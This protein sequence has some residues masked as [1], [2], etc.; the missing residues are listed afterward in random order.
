MD[1][2]LSRIRGLLNTLPRYTRPTIHIAGTNGK[3]SV[4][5]L[6]DSILRQAQ[7]RTGRFNSP[8]LIE[9]RDSIS[10]D[11]NT[12]PVDKYRNFRSAVEKTNTFGA[13]SFE[14]LTVTALQAFEQEGVDIAI[15]EV[16]LGGRLD[17]TN[18]IP[19]D[20]ILISAITS[21]DLDHQ[22][23]LGDTI[24]HIA[25]EKAGI[26]RKGVPLVLGKQSDSSVC[27]AITQVV[28]DAGGTVVRAEDVVTIAAAKKQ[29]I[30]QQVFAL[31]QIVIAYHGHT[32]DA[33]M[34]LLGSHQLDNAAL[35]VAI[36]LQLR[37]M[38]SFGFIT[39]E[40]I[41][42][43]I[44]QARWPGR[45]DRVVVRLQ[46]GASVEVLADGAHN[47]ASATALSDY[48]SRVLP[49]TPRTFILSLSYSPLKTPGSVLRPLLRQGDR[50]SIVPFTPVE[51]MPWVKPVSLD[52]MAVVAGDLIGSQDAVFQFTALDEAL[53]WAAEEGG[54]VVMAGSLY[55]VSD[56]YRFILIEVS[57]SGLRRASFHI[58]I[59]KGVQYVDPSIARID[60]RRICLGMAVVLS[61]RMCGVHTVARVFTVL[62]QSYCYCG[63]LNTV[64][65]RGRQVLLVSTGFSA[66]E[67]RSTTLPYYG[68]R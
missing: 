60:I 61:H 65:A 38:P 62:G 50:V 36:I 28:Q 40:H 52:E 8:H 34:P 30:E 21:V 47:P 13:T 31:D 67:L 23:L 59:F 20:A 45:L 64:I 42:R 25:R 56:L 1:L 24:L 33:D 22:A 3:G 9:V 66:A 15:I 53:T 2:S 4:T 10:I 39:D 11:G 27:G 5:A 49:A 29:S 7:L 17:A 18:V 51:D 32:I 19:D 35:A 12:L 43:G 54:P 63:L 37:H 55:L 41:S 46:T 58:D 57:N 48:L 16:G 6:L 68:Q 26:A 44:S 14:L